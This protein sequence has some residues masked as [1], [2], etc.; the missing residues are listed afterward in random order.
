M[1]GALQRPAFLAMFLARPALS[2]T[3]SAHHLFRRDD[4]VGCDLDGI[5]SSDE[6]ALACIAYALLVGRD[7]GPSGTY[8][9][10]EAIDTE[11]VLAPGDNRHRSRRAALSC[12]S[13]RLCASDRRRT[14]RLSSGSARLGFECVGFGG[15]WRRSGE[16]GLTFDALGSPTVPEH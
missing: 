10:P 4:C 12:P 6:W 11:Q 3:C 8:A 14:F 15:V 1:L 9:R 5:H 7:L 13:C 2:C 16:F